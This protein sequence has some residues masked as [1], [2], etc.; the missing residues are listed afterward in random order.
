L[1]IKSL[2]LMREVDFAEQKTEGE[3]G[4]KKYYPSVKNQI[5]FCQ[6]P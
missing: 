2:P 1:E 4:T 6:L 5:D 3:N